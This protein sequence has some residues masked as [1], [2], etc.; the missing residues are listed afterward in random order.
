MA[1][2]PASKS[3][4]NQ[5]TVDKNGAP[6]RVVTPDQS[7]NFQL[8]ISQ[9]DVAKIHIVDVDM[10][11][12]L[13]DGTKLVLAGGAIGAMDATVMVD[14]SSGRDSAS[15]MLDQVGK[16]PLQKLDQPLVLSTEPVNSDGRGN[17]AED[18]AYRQ[19]EGAQD[20]ASQAQAANAALSAISKAMVQLA[21]VVQANTTPVNNFKSNFD[22]QAAQQQPLV[23]QVAEILPE[24]PGKAPQEF[25]IGPNEPAI[26]IHL[27]N[28][29]GT[30]QIGDVL[31]GSGGS[32]GLLSGTNTSNAA[33]IAPQIIN[34]GNDV[35]TIYATGIAPAAGSNIPADTF[36]KVLD[37]QITGDGK[38]QSLTVSGVPSGMSIVGATSLGGGVYQI[39]ISPDT[40]NYGL[41]LQYNTV[42]PDAGAPIHQDFKLTFSLSVVTADGVQSLT[43][44]KQV[45]VKDATTAN[46]LSYANPVTGES[47]FVLPAQ[48][49]SHIVHAGDNAGT[50]IY[51]SNANDFLYGGTGNDTIYGGKG[52]T[53]FEGGA[54]NDTLVGGVNLVT[55]NVNTVVNTVINT[56]GYTSST[57][58][59]FVDLNTGHALDGFG[60][61]DTL[62]N[63]QKVIGS[64]YDDTFVVGATTKGVDGGLSG[65]DTIDFSA[66]NAAVNVNL[67]TGTG[68][69]GYAQ[70][71][72]FSNIENVVGSSYSD[73]FIASSVANI[74][75]GG[76][77]GSNTVS[78]ANSPSSSTSGVTVDLLNGVG[79]GNDATGDKYINIQNVIGSAYNDTFIA[80]QEANNF[81]GM[82]GINTVSYAGSAAGVEVDFYKGQ[83]AGGN[84]AGDTYKNIQNVI[85][86]SQDDK[87]VADTDS[88]SFDGGAGGNDTVSYERYLSGVI[89][90]AS[91]NVGGIETAPA[92]PQNP[93]GL[94]TYSNSYTNIEKFVGT[95][96]ADTFI[97]S[98]RADN[99]DGL[100]G[101]DTVSY[102]ADTVGVTVNLVTGLGSG[103]GSLADGDRL[104]NIENVI[105]GSGND[106]F[107]ANDSANV[108]D[109]GAGS[110][111]VDYSASTTGAVTVDLFHANGVGTSGG[112]AQGDKFINIQNVIGSTFDDT[113]VASADA[114]TFDGGGGTHN[115]VS[116]ANDTVGVTVDL[117]NGL[118]SG[119][120]SLA[121]GDR[122]INIQDATGGSGDDTF[123]ANAVANSFDG[124]L[125]INTV[126][127]ALSDVGVTVDLV[128]AAGTGG[129]AVGD[130]YT[131]I[132][133]V[134]GSTK[135]DLFIANSAANSFAGNGG[136]DT[137]SYA[138]ATDG[139]GVTVNLDT[140]IGTGGYAE[141]DR[142]QGIQNVIGTSYDD[143]FVASNSVNVFNGGLGVNTVSY[144]ASTSGVTVDLINGT[145]SRGYA[146]GD[147]Y[148]SIQNVIGSSSDDI[149]IANGAV[150]HFD[151]GASMPTSHNR[152]SYAT[153]TANLTIDLLSVGAIGLG[154]NAQGD[155]YTNIQDITGGSGN[156]TFIASAAANAFD[157][158]GGT[159]NRVS[160][161]ADADDLTI[162][163]LTAGAIGLGGNAQGD[164][165]TNI[166]DLTGGAGNDTFI[167]SAAV[168]NFDG[169]GGLHNRVSYASDTADLII[170][171]SD[172]PASGVLAG[173]GSGGYAQGDTYVN[174]QD[175]TGGN[176]NDLFIA[177]L[178]ANNF[179]GGAGTNT[180]S[181]A[182]S[183]SGVIVNLSALAV[184]GLAA[185]TGGGIG[186]YAEGD[187]YT[188]IQNVTGS[189]F[190]DTFIGGAAA[191][192][193]V[194][195]GGSD[196][197]SYAS[198]TT[199]VSINLSNAAVTPTAGGGSLAAGTG[200]GGDAQGDTYTGISNAIGSALGGDEFFANGTLIGTFDGNGGLHDRVNYSGFTSAL[201]INLSD[202]SIAGVAVGKGSVGKANL[203]TYIGIHDATGG[204]GNDTFIAGSAANAFDGGAGI[205]AV[206]YAASDV[207]V[208]VN[209]AGDTRGSLTSMTGGGAAGS[210]AIGDTYTNIQ[211]VVGSNF[212]DLFYASAATGAAANK[213]D[214]GVSDA[215]SHNR[216]SYEAAT[217][218]IIVNLADTAVTVNSTS[219]AANSGDGGAL[220]DTYANI[221]D[222]TGG[223]GADIIVASAAAN[224]ING[225][226]GINNT[227]HYGGSG[228]GVIVNLSGASVTIGSTTVASMTG[229]NATVSASHAAG[230]TY[231]A[232]QNV[233]GSAYN[234]IF[235][236]GTAV[237]VFNGGSAGSDTV[238]YA[239]SGTAVTV[240]LSTAAVTPTAG[241]GSLAKG[242]G[243]GGDA[244][245][246]TYTSISNVTGSTFGGD[247]FFAHN[248]LVGT[249]DGNG[250]THDR[251]SYSG[252]SAATNLIINLSQTSVTVAA[253]TV[254]G[255][256]GS[257]GKSGLDTYIGI[258]DAT[259]GAGNDTFI[260]GVEAN[261]FDG[262][263]GSN[264]VNYAASVVGVVINFAGDTR[265]GLATMAGGGAAGSY[266]IGDTY[267]NIQNV[268]GSSFDDI[269]YASAATGAA[270]NKFDGGV[271]DAG[272]HNRVSYEAV[273]ADVLINLASAT[274]TLNGTSVT[275]GSGAGGAAGD[276]YANI[277]DV[278]GGS[279]NDTFNASAI[280]NRFDGGSG[281]N[282]VSYQSLAGPV[283]IDIKN[284]A[285]SSA[286]QNGYLFYN[287]QNLIGT[288]GNDTLGGAAGGN[289]ILTGGAG[290]DALTGYGLNNTAS[291]AGATAAVTVNLSGASVGGVAARSGKG[292]DAEG[293]TYTGIQNVTGGNG[294][295]LFVASADTN[296][297]NGGAG[298]NTVSYA[299]STA[300]VVADLNTAVGS[301]GDA[302]GDT[303]INIQ[304]LTGT[305]FAD[306]LTGLAVGGSVL[307]G[308]AGADQL[309]GLGY[310]GTD[311]T[312]AAA[313]SNTANYVDSTAGVIINLS[314]V[315]VD[316]L[317]PLG[318]LAAG[319]GRGGD[320]E[321]DV[322]SGIQNLVGSS[323]DDTFYANSQ[324]NRFDGGA[325][326]A[327]SHNKVI[328][329]NVT[330]DLIINLSDT[331]VGSVE[332][333]KGSGSD[334]NLDAYINIQDVTGGGGNDTF[335]SSSAAN[336]FDGG[337]GNNTV[338]YAG[339]GVAVTV[340]LFHM[341]GTDGYAQGDTYANIRNV[342]G[343]TGND[344]FFAGNL[345]S[346]FH[347]GGTADVNTNHGYD[348][349]SYQFATTNL[350]A[351]LLTAGA[352]TGFAAGDTYTRID[353]LVGSATSGVTSNLYGNAFNN[354][355]TALGAA[356]TNLLD[357]GDGDDTLDGIAGGHNTLI[358]G[359]GND[360]FIVQANGVSINSNIDSIA[361]GAGNDTLKI[362]GLGSSLNL[363][364]LSNKVTSIETLD[365][366][367][368]INTNLTVTGAVIAEITGLTNGY[369][370]LTIKLSAG[371]TVSFAGENVRNG[372]DYTSFY[373]VGD[374]NQTGGEIARLHLQY[375]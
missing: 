6:I 102:A 198:S 151:G 126:S 189:A 28:T 167:A 17:G 84:A 159:H 343:T 115:R 303:F 174:I 67:N 220:G 367:T 345:A 147:Q 263:T 275:A 319:K 271:I 248:T 161:A 213:F 111:T 294:N 362:T 34:A 29:V 42:P 236:G 2:A 338:S 363:S 36:S 61:Q 202:K 109:G 185:N 256:K 149:F 155:T 180:V 200:R 89:V 346:L 281:V 244:Q 163:L 14:F 230:D 358:G 278:A 337:A 95:A 157:G 123:I 372:V 366:T 196:T 108:F 258:H 304:N 27:V 49:L 257:V 131:N 328:Y 184:N 92:S 232:I 227:V 79:S 370:L 288:A 152:V 242:T 86:S 32:S 260:A 309:I 53:Y 31:Y 375:V 76:A 359:N 315:T 38:V 106:T 321:G 314:S 332:A 137:V 5:S 218:A 349:V 335:I 154:G 69:G 324:I 261:S 318:S 293:D 48:G 168:N 239:S 219:I 125:G 165:Y 204:S 156:D 181:Y 300:G 356:T 68:T 270:A 217:T 212:D 50:T 59:V 18:A 128:A 252:F 35:R 171:L 371:E 330:G 205:N 135:D 7:G 58:G 46:D 107:V 145:G 143:T 208:V 136:I 262:R 78:Y 169:G 57:A 117:V 51:G 209:F 52:N 305:A 98:N 365:L 243:R 12:Y 73:T 228:A 255:G 93:G 153:D 214:G 88:L 186:S 25:V 175:A 140:R 360:T 340:D 33:Q 81:D 119:V 311:A 97:A 251:V 225:G 206:N 207:G 266:A 317:N 55:I 291:Y 127:Y 139:R 249:F 66:S 250:G 19:T 118:G 40:K 316:A 130:T 269:F 369:H 320:A 158:G 104:A 298:N 342:T 133:N 292:G 350:T 326:N 351:N 120:G 197:V 138:K 272:S 150:N 173:T 238:S 274:A 10:V 47:V 347:G 234:D 99:F 221:Q 259:G 114:N 223:S 121:A 166:Q 231:A 37:V 23:K 336:H 110:N 129:Y 247:E 8:K 22:G 164:T 254:A 13:N 355:L 323:F 264:T 306:K 322:L 142:Y 91:R 94:P 289:S 16:I 246:D 77:G 24:R 245:G 146:Q 187:T 134:I 329:T 54:G 44:V 344:T 172:K 96:Y 178:A 364:S 39:A 334:A 339:N 348:T 105:G 190:N 74:F 60:G 64:K 85:G 82:G 268:V 100:G 43:S 327:S 215:N 226:G 4:T 132:Q 15:H 72:T 1:T 90:D 224:N 286:F 182:S 276:T 179:N 341:T 195:N 237:N 80:N 103:V 352:N 333:G 283:N 310:V 141:G 301:T 361:G 160:Y 285:G 357:G 188:L 148:I 201:T 313:T 282:T 20:L 287:I 235:I 75:D 290:A 284:M 280:T 211:N 9:S 295:D 162:D 83:G 71:V 62:S 312:T 122:L 299:G 296:I 253:V 124:G 279:G 87:F 241:G 183:N 112:F 170:N 331:T 265:G 3:G 308:G 45:V 240:N 65:S 144:A 374:V 273:T 26:A 233:T 353:N 191:N 277:Q 11:L 203:D 194:G 176:G 101:V 297:F 229:A 199:V 21:N 56:V 192:A 302:T 307:I 210:Y 63:I 177:S 30:T 325:S 216:V 116:Y 354:T 193:F 222:I 267:T 373:A 113:F 368:G 70:N 41:E